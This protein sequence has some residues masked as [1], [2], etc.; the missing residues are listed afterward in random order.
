MIFTMDVKRLFALAIF[1]SATLLFMVQPLAGKMLLPVLGGSSA[2][3]STCMVFFQAVLLLGYL[4]AHALSTRVAPR[5]QRPVHVSVLMVAS[6]ALL[7]PIEIGEP[8][9]TD[10]RLWLIRT[11]AR[12]V[13]L[14]FFA[15]S[16][17]AP[18]LQQW[19]SR[20]NDPKARDPYFLPASFQKRSFPCRVDGVRGPGL[21]LVNTNIVRNFAIGGGRTFQF[22]VDVQNLFDAVLWGNPN[23][24]PTST[25]FGK[26][27]GAANSIMRFFTFVMKVNF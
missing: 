22:R 8:G 11:L 21:F 19:F 2:V 13:G 12:T 9:G 10:P 4:Y 7:V 14:P 15:L 27:T 16:A 17:T 26:V 18:L 20:T 3:W 23:L 25:N 6:V 24:N 1:F 5:W